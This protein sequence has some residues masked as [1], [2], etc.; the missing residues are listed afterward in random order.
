MVLSAAGRPQTFPDG[1]EFVRIPGGTFEMGDT[2]GEGL[3]NETPVHTVTLDDFYLSKTEV[4][5]AQYDVFCE[6]TGRRKPGDEGWGRGQL[7]VINVSWHDATAYCQWLSRKTGRDIRL[8][9]EAE[10]EYA[11]REAGKRVR[12]GNGRDTADAREIN[13]DGSAEYEESYSRS[14]IFR[15]KTV[16]VGSFA[17]NALGLYDMSGNVWEWC[18]D[19]DKGNYYKNS[20]SRNPKGPSSGYFRVFRGGSWRDPPEYVRSSVRVNHYPG[21]GYYYHGFR[22]A[23]TD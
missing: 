14:G 7:P 4:T 5:F 18:A 13:F 19:F 15:N 22:L 8:P 16:A 20:P 12:F 21:D 3:S 1:I 10:W 9:T 2:F 23:M 17:P 6:A 11:A